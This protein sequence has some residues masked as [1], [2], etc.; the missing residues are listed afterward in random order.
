MVI[1]LT[2]WRLTALE[3]LRADFLEALEARDTAE[4]ESSRA[5]FWIFGGW[6]SVVLDLIM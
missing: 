1:I 6:F 2:D 4:L 5:S 3:L